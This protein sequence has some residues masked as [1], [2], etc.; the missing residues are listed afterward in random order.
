MKPIYKFIS[1]I[2][3]SL[4]LSAC[5]GK[6]PTEIP[7]I[8][9]ISSETPIPQASATPLALPTFTFIPTNTLPPPE[10]ASFP[11]LPVLNDALLKEN[12]LLAA[13]IY[14][15]TVGHIQGDEICHDVGIYNDDSYI[16]ISCLPDFTYPAPIGTL[17][18]TQ[19]KF[20]HHWLETF[21]HFED[22]SIHGLLKFAGTGTAEPEFSDLVSMQ[23]M[24]G[25]IEW[26]AHEYIHRGGTPSVVFHARSVLSH[27]LNKWLDDSSI[28]KFEVMDF[29]DA[30]LSAPRPNEVCEPIITQGFRIYYI[31]NG[32][33]YEYHTDVWGYDI[34]Q[35][36]EPRAAPTQ[37]A[38]G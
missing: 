34:R 18:A 19:S 20:L 26:A 4:L 17:D 10:L 27:Q 23:A 33:M 22:P 25:E 38:G 2:F 3:T 29:S 31:V 32:L 16:V 37:G 5:V 6:S 13:H 12:L 7:V 9:V 30:C 24:L 36:G 35:F 21:Q 28:L 11:Y 14:A 15:D 8:S 1:L